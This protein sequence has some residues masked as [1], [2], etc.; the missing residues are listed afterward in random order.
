MG[1]VVKLEGIREVEFRHLY[2]APGDLFV[3]K[4]KVY[5]VKC[6]LALLRKTSER[7]LGYWRRKTRKCTR[8]FMASEET[9]G[10]K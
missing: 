1:N 5:K 8:L 7:R 6:D 4:R 10:R 2:R 9:K 3:T